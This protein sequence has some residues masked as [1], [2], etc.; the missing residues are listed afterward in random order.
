MKFD[1]VT[2]APCLIPPAGDTSCTVKPPPVNEDAVL[3]LRPEV[4]VVEVLGNVQYRTYLVANG[5]EVEVTSGLTYRT[6]NPTIAIIGAIGGNAT[7]LSIGITQVSV[8]WQN[9]EAFAQLQVVDSCDGETVGMM[10]VVDRSESMSQAFGAPFGTKLSFAKLLANQFIGEV[11][12]TKDKVGLVAFDVEGE[13]VEP[14][15]DDSAAVAAAVMGLSIQTTETDITSG[16]QTAIDNLTGVDR[17]VIVLITDG[18]HNDDEEPIIL[19]QQFRSGGG[20]IIVVALRAGT[21]AFM[22]LEKVSSGGFFISAFNQE[23][24]ED[25][26]H[27]LS[28]L[29]GYLC[30]GNCCPEGD[31]FMPTGK[32]N[33]TSWGEWNV[34]GG[35]VDLI[36]AGFF[37]FL[38]GNGLYMDLCG[39]GP[40]FRGTVRTKRVFNFTAGQSFRLTYRLAG[41]QRIDATPYSVRVSVGSLINRT[42]DLND[43]RQDFTEYTDDFTGDGSQGQILFSQETV[44]NNPQAQSFGCLLDRVKLENLTTGETLIFD[45]FDNE[46]SIYQNPKCGPGTIY[47]Y[48]PGGYGYAY[49]YCCYGYGCLSEPIV[50]QMPDP[51]PPD[52]I[53]VDGNPVSYTATQSYTAECP[54]GTEGEPVTRT[55]TYKSFISLA[56]ANAKALEM[57]QEQAEAALECRNEFAVGEIINI[58]FTTGPDSHKVGIGPIGE[59]PD[60]QWNSSQLINVDLR[61][62]RGFMRSVQMSIVPPVDSPSP[63]SSPTTYFDEV[64]LAHADE[65]YQTGLRM[66]ADSE[67]EILRPGAFV[68]RNMPEG[69][70]TLIVMA[71]GPTEDEQCHIRVKT[72]AVLGS[73]GPGYYWNTS[74][75]TS[76]T[77]GTHGGPGGGHLNFAWSEGQNYKR[78]QVTVGPGQTAILVE[79][80]KV[81][82]GDPLGIAT[83]N[84]FQ[85]QRTS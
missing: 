22:R 28:G 46:N 39:S 25:A 2:T 15:T 37:D 24:G 23:T 80:E 66:F 16:L 49:G 68:L 82:A 38:P 43:W 77:I 58:D 54:D 72:G 17:R 74:G 59:F 78:F 44:P 69:N 18:Q 12:T 63:T 5:V 53:E 40:L 67:L 21:D 3:I 11:N 84:A 34:E 51:N 79:I 35:E 57:A 42:R 7:G 62:S 52:D 85:I 65:S 14:L 81:N 70:Y 33:Y 13:L 71:H 9:L 61:N 29:K 50:A 75:Q 55:V 1:N 4:A 36:G 60:D 64:I 19:A 76:Y 83:V 10:V 45:T 31:M 41:N 26:Q 20:I 48:G 47:G 30:A 8:T 73:G 56:D 27:Y 6:A 32:L